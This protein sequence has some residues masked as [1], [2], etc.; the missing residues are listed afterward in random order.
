M[1]TLH[2]SAKLKI[3]S[4][5]HEKVIAQKVYDEKSKTVITH[6]VNLKA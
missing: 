5:D 6:T 3:I 2:L 4:I 1:L